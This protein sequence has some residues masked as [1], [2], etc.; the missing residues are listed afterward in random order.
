MILEGSYTFAG[1]RDVVFE[2]LQDPEVLVK[3]LPGAKRLERVG[4]N[5]FE[6]EMNVGIGPVSAAAFT[7][8]VTLSDSTPPES[9]TMQFEG[10][11]AIGFTRGTATVTLEEAEGGGGT[12]M[13]YH[14]DLKVGGKIAGVGQRLLDSV[15]KTMTKQGLEAMN[16]ELQQR[17]T[18]RPASR[19][20]GGVGSMT[21][22]VLVVVAALVVLWLVF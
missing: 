18:G 11:G 21:V 12:V 7:V 16:R 8:A 4:E 19:A 5:R 13:A 6:G 2:L 14:A 20:G 15:S 17:L 9:F 10:K 3:A 1:P 22:A